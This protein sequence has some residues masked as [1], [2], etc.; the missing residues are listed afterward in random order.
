[1]RK[2]LTLFVLVFLSG[3][4]FPLAQ[5]T[6]IITIRKTKEAPVIDGQIE[7][8]WGKPAIPYLTICIPNSK[9]G[10]TPDNKTRVYLLYDEAYLYLA[11][12]CA[13]DDI[14]GLVTDRT[15][16]MRR[17]QESMLTL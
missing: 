15:E 4:P 11:F 13:D 14:K 8:L 7:K 17:R 10:E 9:A 2:F 12:A 5:G 1:M 3:G 16:E 6:E